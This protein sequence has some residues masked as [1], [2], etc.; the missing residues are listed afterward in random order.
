ML[1]CQPELLQLLITPL[2][3]ELGPLAQGLRLG[4]QLTTGGKLGATTPGC[5]WAVR[6][7]L[8]TLYPDLSFEHVA[9]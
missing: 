2:M 6:T 4:V 8:S 7:E 3:Q 1:L 5:M 9:H